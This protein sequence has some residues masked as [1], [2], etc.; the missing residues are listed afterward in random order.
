MQFFLYSNRRRFPYQ[1]FHFFDPRRSRN[2]AKTR[3]QVR[4]RC[5]QCDQIGWFLMS[6][7]KNILLKEAQILDDIFGYFD[8]DFLLNT[9]V[10]PLLGKSLG[11]IRQ[12]FI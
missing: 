4:F 7:L 10:D 11:V 8:K 12:F 5:V 2:L 9:V 3:F 6:L 1:A